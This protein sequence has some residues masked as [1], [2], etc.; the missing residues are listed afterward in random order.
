MGSLRVKRAKY[1]GRFY[2]TRDYVRHYVG[3]CRPKIGDEI[4]LQCAGLKTCQF[5]P[6]C[7][8]ETV[9]HHNCSDSLLLC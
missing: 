8:D 1:N 9:Y 5:I 2:K 4:Y 3:Q 6:M 7:L